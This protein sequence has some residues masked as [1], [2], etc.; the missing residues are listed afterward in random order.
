MNSADDDVNPP[1]LHII[2]REIKKVKRGRFILLPITEETVDTAH[3]PYLRSGENTWRSSS[4]S[5]N[6]H[7]VPKTNFRMRRDTVCIGPLIAEI[8]FTRLTFAAAIS[9]SSNP[10][11]T[12]DTL[13]IAL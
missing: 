8:Q 13:L 4:K 11:W 6:D 10:A 3:T 1:E 12:I 5:R 7:S 9:V 2:E